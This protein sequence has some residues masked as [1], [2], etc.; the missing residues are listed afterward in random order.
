MGCPVSARPFRVLS[1]D[2][3]GMRGVYTSTYLADLADAFARKRRVAALDVGKGFDLIAG[4][5]TGGIVACALASGIP[6]RDVV[7][8]YKEHGRAIF[9]MKLPT[10]TWTRAHRP[11]LL[12][13][14]CPGRR[15]QVASRDSR[16]PV[17]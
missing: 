14:G 7:S 9:P 1:L 12:A 16:G 10:P 17:R 15:R 6:L 3:G 5:S 11:A 4:T 2:G 8:L 13:V